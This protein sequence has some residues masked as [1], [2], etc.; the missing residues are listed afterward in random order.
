MQP[1]QTYHFRACASNSKGAVCGSDASFVTSQPVNRLP[2]PPAN[3]AQLKSDL[4][5]EIPISGATDEKAVFF[6][7]DAS[8]PDGDRVK[9]QIE[10][11]RIDEYGG[12]L[13]GGER[14]TQQSGFVS[15]GQISV[16]AYGLVN[17]NYHW[18]ARAVDEYGLAS[19][20][21]GFGGNADSEK[22]FSVR[23][24]SLP[25]A[26]FIYS[27]QTPEVSQEV[28]FDASSSYD[29]DGGALSYIWEFGDGSSANGVHASHAYPATGHYAVALTVTDDDG[30][31]GRYYMNMDIFSKAL[32]ES[33]T[34]M[35]DMA[36]GML[37]DVKRG[38][39]DAA[40]AA[41]HFKGESTEDLNGI[42]VGL[43][44]EYVNSFLPEVKRVSALSIADY[45]KLSEFSP[46]LA[47]LVYD[48]GWVMAEAAK[49][50]FAECMEG[51]GIGIAS[52]ITGKLMANG[53]Y[54]TF[55]P[56]LDAII[57][58]KKARLDEVKN[59]ALN[60]I[61][62]LTQEEI[63][64]Y[65]KDIRMRSAGTAAAKDIYTN[66]ASLPTVLWEIEMEEA[67]DWKL[68]LA[69]ISLKIGLTS[70]SIAL[71]GMGS[72]SL[73]VATAGK[74]FGTGAKAYD[75]YLK[76][77]KL[78][79]DGQ[80]LMA[81]AAALFEGFTTVD[82]ISDNAYQG[83]KNIRD[84]ADPSIPQGEIISIEHFAEG[85]FYGEDAF[86]NKP[87]LIAKKLYSEV[88]IKNTGN[89]KAVYE[90][91]ISAVRS[92]RTGYKSHELPIVIG[93]EQKEIEPG[94]TETITAWY[95]NGYLDG[96]RPEDQCVYFNLFGET[97]GLY[98]LDSTSSCFGTT[99]I[100][101]NEA[102]ISEEEL[103]HA[104][105]LPCPISS[106]ISNSSAGHVLGIELENPFEM[107]VTAILV[108][109]IPHTID[110]IS[111]ENGT[112]DGNVSW[113]FELGPKEKR[114][115][116]AMFELKQQ[117]GEAEIPG[118]LLKIYD[119]VNDHWIGFASNNL[120]IYAVLSGDANDDGV[121]NIFDFA[122]VGL[123]FGSRP[124][125]ANWNKHAD[126]N[127]DGIVSIFDLAVVG[128]NFGRSH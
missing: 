27:P 90:L 51:M 50:V 13:L 96:F 5:A 67:G 7:A 62:S 126:V 36:S 77:S 65:I 28:N 44:F 43:A 125:I 120:S 104:P 52:D 84:R 64:T 114:G 94:Q 107:P 95:K 23:V 25:I 110:V 100:A 87:P 111:A 56:K 102:N 15:G 82:R 113:Q 54:W 31:E 71:M 53:S 98:L 2:N 74:G 121:V 112:V 41:D 70:A 89:V 46:E 8:D 21:V 11:R 109:E 33:I 105:I 30:S 128:L 79:T 18:Q 119:Q 24:N 29:P 19:G 37:D 12:A 73:L 97:D 115:F 58:H 1:S 118:A 78:D 4:V 47:R 76:F 40:N 127:C 86:Y 60:S 117:G 14:F 99:R 55:V 80:M 32:E 49:R 38:A 69:D 106:E 63:S 91:S 10:L 26:A 122:I 92:F 39:M 57:N 88:K 124:G 101:T 72:P 61:G 83:L 81:S 17:G 45:T 59:E 108:Q 20:W 93:T 66:K 116:D 42:V 68:I 123:A 3:P 48:E 34:E 16:A 6:R 35:A 75:Y 103:Q 85:P 22:D 9:L